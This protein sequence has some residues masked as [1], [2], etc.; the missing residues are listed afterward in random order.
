MN[1]FH[2]FQPSASFPFL[3]LAPTNPQA[4]EFDFKSMGFKSMGYSYLLQ[5]VKSKLAILKNIVNSNAY[6]N[7]SK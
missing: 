6:F 5:I 3:L 2:P 1:D 7:C 4:H